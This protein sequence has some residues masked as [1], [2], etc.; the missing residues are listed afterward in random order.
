MPYSNKNSIFTT[1]LIIVLLSFSNLTSAQE[2]NTLKPISTTTEN[3]EFSQN[4]TIVSSSSTELN[5]NNISNEPVFKTQQVS[6]TVEKQQR[7]INLSANLS[8]RFDAITN[9]FYAIIRRL[10]SR[11]NLQLENVSVTL[12]N[13]DVLVQVATTSTDPLNNWTGVR[14][15]YKSANTSIHNCHQS[16]RNVVSLL[17]N[18]ANPVPPGPENNQDVASTTN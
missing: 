3:L 6:L 8:N 7:I 2:I 11:I 9:R 12:K 18:S 5:Q 16:L 4:N 17:K 1:S 13:I 14:E 15:T 10:D